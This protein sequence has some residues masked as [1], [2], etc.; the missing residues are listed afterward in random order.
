[1][2]YKHTHTKL[3]DA[4]LSLSVVKQSKSLR[5]DQRFTHSLYT[6]STRLNVN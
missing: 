3:L 4:S 1:M 6:P 5:R 2:Q